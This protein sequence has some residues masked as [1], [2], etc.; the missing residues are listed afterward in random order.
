MGRRERRDWAEQDV[1]GLLLDR[2]AQEHWTHGRAAG[3][4]SRRAVA[5]TLHCVGESQ[6]DQEHHNGHTGSAAPGWRRFLPKDWSEDP[7]RRAQAHV[8][9]AGGCQARNQPAL[10]LV[11][12]AL[13]RVASAT[14]PLASMAHLFLGARR[15]RVARQSRRRRQAKP[16][17]AKA[18]CHPAPAPCQ[19]CL[20]PA[21]RHRQSSSVS[22]PNFPGATARHPLHQRLSCAIEPRRGSDDGPRSA[23]G[24][25]GSQ[26]AI[27]RSESRM[28]D[29]GADSLDRLVRLSGCCHLLFF[30]SRTLSGVTTTERPPSETRRES[31]SDSALMVLARS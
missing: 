21:Q 31:C 27:E 11:R 22:S 5:V 14:S 15:Q 24:G 18:T 30:D 13:E 26:P 28:D 20:K 19:A 29:S 4:G 9:E 12:E 17:P 25:A 23:I 6:A 10:E 1:R 16:H 7:A 3:T 8:P 2:G